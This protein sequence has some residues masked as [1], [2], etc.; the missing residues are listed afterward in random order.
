MGETG[1]AEMKALVTA[2]NLG[3]NTTAMPCLPHTQ[4]PSSMTCPAA[5]A[6]GI[7]GTTHQ[8]PISGFIDGP[9]PT[10]KDLADGKF[11]INLA[12]G[13]A[14]ALGVLGCLCSGFVT[15]C[16]VRRQ[17]RLAKATALAA[18]SPPQPAILTSKVEETKKAEA[19]A[20]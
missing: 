7:N 18:P 20:V 4:L 1:E 13:F 11:M 16:V 17:T 2:T 10:S 12:T 5:S 9:Y 15:I 6:P 8:V 19:T 3:V 14:I